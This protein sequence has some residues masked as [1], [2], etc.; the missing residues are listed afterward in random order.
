MCPTLWAQPKTTI[1]ASRRLTI[2]EHCRANHLKIIPHMIS[3]DLW[4]ASHKDN[5]HHSNHRGRIAGAL[6]HHR[7]NNRLM[8][9]NPI[10][11]PL[12]Y[13][14]TNRGTIP[15]NHRNQHLQYQIRLV[16]HLQLIQ[17]PPSTSTNNRP[18]P[19]PKRK[20]KAPRSASHHILISS[21]LCN[22]SNR[23]TSRLQPKHQ[24]QPQLSRRRV[25]LECHHNLP[26][27]TGNI[28][29]HS[30]HNYLR[31]GRRSHRF[32]L[33]IPGTPRKHFPWHPSMRPNSLLSRRPLLSCR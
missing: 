14:S 5:T 21:S 1:P 31:F 12:M 4:S 10:M 15:N 23:T 27:R 19:N 16:Q 28:A 17:P 11:R 33:H 9:S 20:P 30:R 22:H 3:E 13:R 29:L 8:H 24:G 2:P 18:R 7:H 26:S 6:T 32:R 25:N